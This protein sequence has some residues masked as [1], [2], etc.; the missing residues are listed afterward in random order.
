VAREDLEAKIEAA[1][2]SLPA[3]GGAAGAVPPLASP[4]ATVEV[5]ERDLPTNYIR[6]EF[7]TPHPGDP[8]YPAVRVAI[9]ILSDRLNEEVRTKRNL[10]YAVFAGLSQRRANYGLV[11]VTAVEPD[12]TLE[13]ILHEFERMKTEPI[14]AERLAEN[15]NVFLTL[16]WLGQETNMGQAATL[17]T[18]ELVGDGWE[19]AAEFV[20]RVRAVTPADIQRVAQ[21]YFRDIRFAVIG[22]PDGIDTTLFTSL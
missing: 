5:T 10:S 3:T 1:F 16:Y 15:I 7:S 8:D 19:N 4:G 13:V 11:Y 9:D 21:T 2:G 20:R 14:T 17:G 6:G 18:F 12:T 22:N